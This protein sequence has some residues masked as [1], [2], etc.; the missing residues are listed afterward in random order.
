MPDTCVP[1]VTL[2]TGSIVPVAVMLLWML[3]RSTLV[4]SNSTVGL[5][6]PPKKRKQ[7]ATRAAMITMAMMIVFFMFYWFEP[8]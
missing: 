5:E 1:T 6:E 8:A 7:A 2:V 3:V 4:F